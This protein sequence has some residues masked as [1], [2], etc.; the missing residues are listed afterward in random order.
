MHMEENSE[1]KQWQKK[2]HSTYQNHTKK[3]AQFDCLKILNILSDE[4][5]K[6]HLLCDA[7]SDLMKYWIDTKDR[8]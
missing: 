8:C 3:P 1:L 5:F 6:P 4:W 2:K 7:R